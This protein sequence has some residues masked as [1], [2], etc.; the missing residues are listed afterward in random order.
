MFKRKARTPPTSFVS[1]AD[2]QHIIIELHEAGRPLPVDRWTAAL[3]ASVTAMAALAAAAEDVGGAD[4]AEGA[5]FDENTL[6]LEAPLVARID[7]Q[8][9]SA[10]GLPAPTRLALDIR[11]HGRIDEDG[12]RITTRWVQPGGFPVKARVDGALISSEVGVRR[13]PEPLWSLHAASLALCA[14]LERTERFKALA[15]LQ[16]FWPEDAAG[17][18]ESDSYLKDLRIHYAAG[19][20][21][22]IGTLTPDRTE[23]DPVLFSPGAIEDAPEGGLDEAADGVLSPAAQ[24]L[25]A[26]DRFRREAHARPVYVLR[27]GEYVF[28]DP[29]L[30]PAL[31]VVRRLQDAPEDERRR[32]VLNPRAVF[33]ERLGE[34]L[35]EEIGLERLF[36]ETDQFSARVSGVDVWRAPVLP[37]LTPAAGGGWLPE[38]FGLR[39]GDTYHTIEAKDVKTLVGRV[40]EGK[41]AGLQAV[42]IDDLAR[43]VDGCSSAEAT[44]LPLGERTDAALEA[45]RPFAGAIPQVDGSASE[46]T[47]I[48]PPTYPGKLFLVVRDNFEDVEYIA[49]W[50]DAPPLP[51]SRT[52]AP[53]MLRSQLKPHQQVGL[54]WL[55]SAARAG[56]PGVLLADDMGLGKTLQAIAFMAWRRAEA[57]AGRIEP[58]PCL[59]V[60]PTGLL[61][62]W[63]KEI[64]L[65]LLE[66]ALGPLVPA[67]GGSLRELREEDAFS[68]RD[69]ETGRAALSAEAW[70][71][72]GV[73]LT[74]YETMRDYHF[75]FARTR[76]GA[77]VF[78]EVQRLKNPASQV[79]RASLSL[80]ADFTIGMT[81][82]PVE[83]RLQDLWSIMNAVAP[84]V[85]GSSR[86]FERRHAGGDREALMALK[87]RLCEPQNGLPPLLLRRMKSDILAG[88]PRKHVHPFRVEMPQLQADAYRDVVVRAATA[89]A[90]NNLGKSGM[91]MAL[92]EMRGISLH[93]L[94]PR[95]APDDLDGYAAH[96]A[97]L[98]HSLDVLDGV[99]R[100]GEKAL[101]FVEDL[102]MQER[103]AVLIQSRF[104]LKR[105]PSRI[106]GQVP[107]PRRQQIVDEFQSRGEGFDVLILSPRAGGVGLTITAAN[108]VIHLSRWW[109]PAVEDQATDR[110]FRIGQEREV[111]VHLPLAVHPDPNI[112]PSSFDLRL[113]AL[114]ERKRALT[115]EL[116]LPPEAS[117]AD[118]NYLFREVSM[119]ED[120]PEGALPEQDPSS[121]PPP[122]P[123]TEAVEPDSVVPDVAPP[124]PTSAEPVAPAPR[125]VLSIAAPL[126]EPQIRM[127]RLEAGDRRPLDELMA[128][129]SGK[130]VANVIIRDP[131]CLGTSSARSAQVR[132]IK[133]LADGAR[134][135][136]SASLEYAPEID[137]DLDESGSRRDVG[138]L[139]AREF[140]GGGGPR[141]N[142]VRR[143]RRGGSDDFHD[144]FVDIDVRGAGGAVDRHSISIGRGVEALFDASRQCTVTYV[145]PTRAML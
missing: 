142:L 130:S 70:R 121:P 1:R 123:A 81:G 64:G 91:L 58:A 133:A 85:L 12:F 137:G 124:T 28:I 33:R 99:A 8:T 61:G 31:D 20:S 3:P 126:R 18:V 40:E 65:H 98:I 143:R 42:R 37:W 140:P 101:V 22:K 29:A 59:I 25:F 128:I 117:D 131:Y 138:S 113:D 92:S 49:P 16:Q 100:K 72:A 97:R 104:K 106:N 115:S 11:P 14:P 27:N 119:A 90:A 13:V 67:F 68:G 112:G 86:D 108:H 45:L 116:F 15:H 17:A 109:N 76:W 118:V 26:T 69:I 73:V 139:M 54:D 39:I 132:F 24:K 78:D 34:E 134:V 46:E 114:I 88:L 4:G 96:S 102:A 2:G 83:N 56:L 135:I 120:V 103:L 71:D 60:A 136:E 9:A 125:L 35:A 74:T 50:N 19:L 62:T 30:R 144:R 66:P 38:R 48:P 110:V 7:S 93:P 52:D 47:G 82:T 10:L 87:D 23:F 89:A 75:S 122:S 53:A 111:H 145:P 5:C 79:S 51:P 63:R 6:T 94:D 129:F 107:G 57:E 95:N 84:G 36:V 44:M 41:A 77:I 32:F 21:L 55:V 141:L 43:P 80:N 105:L 127:W